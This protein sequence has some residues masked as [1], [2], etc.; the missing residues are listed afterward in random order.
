[1]IIGVF[2][3][4]TF[5]CGRRIEFEIG[6]DEGA[7]GTEGQIFLVDLTRCGKLDGIIP[8]KRMAFRYFHSRQNE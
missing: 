4:Q 3:D 5:G 2:D 6:G 8:S 1:M 7:V